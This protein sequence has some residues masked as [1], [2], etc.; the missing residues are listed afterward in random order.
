MTFGKW[1][2][3]VALILSIYIIWQIR[4]ITLLLFT[5]I[6]LAN[7]LNVLVIK[8]QAGASFL[9]HK[10]GYKQLNIS[11]GYAVVLTLFIFLST[12]INFFWLIVPSFISQ[13][14]Q[15][16]VKVPQGIEKL[17]LLIYSLIAD[18]EQ[19]FNIS[20]GDFSPRIQDFTTEQLPNLFN[21]LIDQGFLLIS[22]SLGVLL[23]LLL[24]LVLTLML[25]ADPKPYLNGFIRL[26]PSFYRHRAREILLLCD[27]ALEGWIVGIVFNM[28]II[29]ILSLI[30]LSVLGI[31]L[32]LANAILAGILTFIPNIGP[33]LSVISPMAIALLEHPWKAWGVLILYI[34]I[35]QIEGNILTPLV[36]ARQVSLLPAVTLMSQVFFANFFGFLGLFIALPLMVVFQVLIQEILMKDILDQW[37][38]AGQ[39]E[40]TTI[41]TSSTQDPE[42]IDHLPQL[43]PTNENNNP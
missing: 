40:T 35:Q 2:G 39:K 14:E 10:F 42:N 31:P 27:Q 33:A 12:V 5:A 8:L 30:S 1:L 11:R 21:H 16:A 13:F 4:Q 6:I 9:A 3:F 20:I 32:A 28:L 24:L 18:L 23:N 36:M 25:L 26:F 15:L 19:E 43:S 41:T 34:I 22:S 17:E 29:T 37:E 38:L 7:V